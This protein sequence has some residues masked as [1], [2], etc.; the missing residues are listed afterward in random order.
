M[1]NRIVRLSVAVVLGTWGLYAVGQQPRAPD[2]PQS[3][4]QQTPSFDC[5]RA[6]TA[7]EHNI[8]SDESLMALDRK[9]SEA[10][11]HWR[12]LAGPTARN[13]QRKWLLERDGQ[14]GV[15][16]KDRSIACLSAI[17]QERTTFL[18]GQ[19]TLLESP[20]A[21]I[22][23]SD[24]ERRAI[25][26]TLRDQ[27]SSNRDDTDASFE[28]SRLYAS[29]GLPYLAINELQ[30][31]LA[32]SDSSIA[33][34]KRTVC[35]LG[36]LFRTTARSSLSDYFAYQC[37]GNG[38]TTEDR[39]EIV[40]TMER[41]HGTVH[42][43]PSNGNEVID[44]Y[45]A[46]TDVEVRIL[47]LKMPQDMDYQF[48]KDRKNYLLEVVWKQNEVLYGLSEI[49][50]LYDDPRT[51]FDYPGQPLASIFR[52]FR[53]TH[54]PTADELDTEEAGE[55][56]RLFLSY[57]GSAH[58]RLENIRHQLQQSSP[59]GW[60]PTIRERDHQ[61]F[62]SRVREMEQWLRESPVDPSD[63]T[64]VALFAMPQ[65]TYEHDRLFTNYLSSISHPQGA[66][67]ADQLLVR[68]QLPCRLYRETA[69]IVKDAGRAPWD[70]FDTR[71][72][73]ERSSAPSRQA[74]ADKSDVRKY[75]DH[76]Y[77]IDGEWRGCTGS[78]Y[79]N[80][81]AGRSNGI[82]ALEAPA[83]E[84]MKT[85]P[86]PDG[87]EYEQVFRTG[88]SWWGHQDLTSYQTYEQVLELFRNA[89]E[90]RARLYEAND[91]LSAHRARL[92]ASM[93]LTA[94]AHF[95]SGISRYLSSFRPNNLL[96][97]LET[98]TVS[99]A[100][101][102]TLFQRDSIDEVLRYL[103]AEGYD[104]APW[105]NRLPSEPTQ[106]GR[107]LQFSILHP[108]T[109]RELLEFGFSPDEGDEIGKSALMAAAQFD[110]IESAR[111]LIEAGADPNSQLPLPWNIEGNWGCKKWIRHGKR[112]PLMYAAQSG[113][114]DMLQ[115]LLEHGAD[116]NK[117]DSQGLRAIDYLEGRG[118]LR[119]INQNL[120]ADELD[121]ARDLLK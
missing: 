46:L 7:V 66:V 77:R 118:P 68:I 40:A 94:A 43:S 22:N 70:Q 25:A 42:E 51:D 65:L 11:N 1:Q 80:V 16:D 120:D 108:K 57:V 47:L 100:D 69:R 74:I 49:S 21:L 33:Q 61:K 32:R 39:P 58:L 112:T 31:I 79:R 38:K 53:L 88:F 96:L 119:K 87:I 8:C 19:T 52:A 67:S 71:C 60:A 93:G 110:K 14:C 92:M 20:F 12:A 105:Y 18:S 86:V 13:M 50:N 63:K 107:L 44:A 111:L 117:P 17:M 82:Q 3:S 45:I 59:N 121:M 36:I 15:L 85:A 64:T 10:Y 102:R 62:S 106:R 26:L 6:I 29:L 115:L 4:T 99:E 84:W 24:Q 54:N 95:S 81:Y 109:A 27:L 48:F 103:A 91:G 55:L 56:L 98:E 101:I 83:T 34:I 2:V 104:L 23:K 72:P 89:V 78:N 113:S 97:K 76:V 37:H 73:S 41:L 116:R 114:L 75:F 5:R 28:L 90:E 9:V 35:R 30:H